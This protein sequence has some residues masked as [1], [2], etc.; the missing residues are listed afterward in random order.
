LKIRII[1]RSRLRFYSECEFSFFD[2]EIC[3]AF[4]AYMEKDIG[5]CGYIGFQI[6]K[7]ASNLP[8]RV[9]LVRV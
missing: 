2:A 9:R 1:Y 8:Y 5:I 6:W 4:L 7:R 3:A